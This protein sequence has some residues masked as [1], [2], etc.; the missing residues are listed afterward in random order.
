MQF[1]F[2][3]LNFLLSVVSFLRDSRRRS[4]FHFYLS[5]R[6][7]SVDL[8][9]DERRSVILQP[10]KIALVLSLVGVIDV[11]EQESKRFKEYL[12]KKA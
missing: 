1:T 10:D 5:Q 7:R 2:S 6:S 11:F 9:A 12:L 3:V 8:V 4:C